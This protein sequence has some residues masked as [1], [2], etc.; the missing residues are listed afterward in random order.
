[1]NGHYIRESQPGRIIGLCLPYLEKAGFISPPPAQDATD[2]VKLAYRR[3]LEYARRVIILEQDRMKTITEIV[4]LSRFFFEEMDYPHGYDSK[5]TE[6]WFGVQYLRPLLERELAAWVARRVHT[7]HRRRAWPEIRRGDPSDSRGRDRP[8]RWSRPI[9]D[10]LGAWKG[11]DASE[12]EIGAGE[13]FC[14]RTRS[15]A[16]TPRGLS[17]IQWTI[18][19]TLTQCSDRCRPPAPIWR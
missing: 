19:S 7:R 13:P 3:E 14:S 4:D 18:L 1:M 6:K 15:A 12:T 9:R 2:D 11:P 5:A 16:I 17:E 8:H 10:A